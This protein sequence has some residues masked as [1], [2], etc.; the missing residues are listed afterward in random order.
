MDEMA[1]RGRDRSR[2]P[3]VA[4]R[5]HDASPKPASQQCIGVWPGRR[6]GM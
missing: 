1:W 4:R 6:S 3:L 5:R 2:P